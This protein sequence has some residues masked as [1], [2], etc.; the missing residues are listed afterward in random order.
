MLSFLLIPPPFKLFVV[1]D[2]VLLPPPSRGEDESSDSSLIPWKVLLIV[3]EEE[4][5]GAGQRRV[6]TSRSSRDTLMNHLLVDDEVDRDPTRKRITINGGDR[7]SQPDGDQRGRL[8]LGLLVRGTLRGRILLRLAGCLLVC[9]F[10][11]AGSLCLCP[12]RFSVE[13]FNRT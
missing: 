12:R 3:E 5:D 1:V 2:L 9:V 8:R 11:S 4:E 7:R 13:P 10:F 6:E